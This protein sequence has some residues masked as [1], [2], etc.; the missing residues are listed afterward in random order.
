M[1]R[2]SKMS[3]IALTASVFLFVSCKN[4]NSPTTTDK[5]DLYITVK[6]NT[7]S[8]PLTLTISGPTNFQ[9]VVGPG[10]MNNSLIAFNWTT[11]NY[12]LYFNGG[13]DGVIHYLSGAETIKCSPASTSSC[14]SWTYTVLP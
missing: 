2:Y 6:Q 9:D 7:P 5:N 4:S 11:G 1:G 14:G 10:A 3:G 13:T 12:T 8:C